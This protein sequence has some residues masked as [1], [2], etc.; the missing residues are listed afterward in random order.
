[1][2]DWPEVAADIKR[3]R[4]LP[5]FMYSDDAVYAK[6]LSKVF[7][8]SWQLV[9]AEYSLATEASQVSPFVLL[10]DSLDE[11]LLLVNDE[12]GER[13]CLSN[14][15]THRGMLIVQEAGPLSHL[16]CGYHGR[17]FGLTGKMTAMP[18]FE[19][20]ANFPGPDDDLK[21]TGLAEWG[22]LSFVQLLPGESFA[23]VMGPLMQA[24][25]WL[26]LAEFKFDPS[27]SRD[28][29]VKAH[30]ALY[31]ENFLEGFHIPFVHPELNRR[32][33]WRD[34]EVHLHQYSSLQV[35]VASAGDPTFELPV[36]HPDHGKAI[37]AYYW[38]VAPNLMFNFYPWGLSVNI[39]EP[40]GPR[41]CRVRFQSHVWRP[42]L[43]DHGAGG[44]LDEVEQEDEA[45]V[46]AVQRGVVSRLYRRGRYSPTHERGTHH[47]HRLWLQQ[48]QG[49][50]TESNPG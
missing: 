13:R 5:G 46:E 8:P 17:T 26:P 24:M 41:S 20:A 50:E 32:L 1:M 40:T 9:P 6:S 34:Y 2:V 11:S 12:T 23:A 42:E 39:V 14:V 29:E 7:A 27:R 25:S 18:G 38:F 33:A 48:L 19:M 36:D 44:P 35:G 37:A 30:W 4:T 49:G 28:Y 16:R 10:P 15:C 22:P 31:C 47:F 45:V 3:A 43:L 21:T